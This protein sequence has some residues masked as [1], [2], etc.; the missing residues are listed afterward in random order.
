L[1]GFTSA[2]TGA[3]VNCHLERLPLRQTRSVELARGAR[4]ERGGAVEPPA[5]GL[6]VPLAGHLEGWALGAGTEAE[7][8]LLP[9]VDEPGVQLLLVHF[10]EA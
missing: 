1:S 10:P 2:G 4:E 3:E 8:V 9:H 7:V 5:A 6:R